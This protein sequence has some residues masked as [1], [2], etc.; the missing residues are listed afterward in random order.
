MTDDPQGTPEAP[1]R[2]ATRV[3]AGA[4]G[5]VHGAPVG[6]PQRP[7]PGAARIVRQSR[8]PVGRVPGGGHVA[9]FVILC[10]SR[11]GV[12]GGLSRPRRGGAS[13]DQVI[14]IERGYNI[15]GP[16]ARIAT[17]STARRQRPILNRQDKLFAHL[18]PDYIGHARGGAAAANAAA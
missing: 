5:P 6:A 8:R 4:D 10:A 14:S 1:A 15:C 16:T 9:L 2:A 7:D 11:A 18:N 12:P 3:P 13:A 17:A